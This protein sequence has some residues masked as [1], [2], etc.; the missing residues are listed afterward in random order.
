MPEGE[1]ALTPDKEADRLK[2][3]ARTI[4][5]LASQGLR[6]KKDLGVLHSRAHDGALQ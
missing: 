6:S 1:D 3:L 2:G 5:G 4:R